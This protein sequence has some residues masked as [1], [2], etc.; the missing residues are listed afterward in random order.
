LT[1]LIHIVPIVLKL[2]HRP[3]RRRSISWTGMWNLTLVR[4]VQILDWP[5]YVRFTGIAGEVRSLDFGRLPRFRFQTQSMVGICQ[6]SLY[7][8]ID[9]T[10][11]L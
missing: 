3:P 9:R 2:C 10:R 4:F 6:V 7:G 11:G 5:C 1:S 8:C